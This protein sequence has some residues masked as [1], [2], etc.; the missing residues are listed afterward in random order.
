MPFGVFVE[1]PEIAASGLVHVSLL[2]HRFL[3]YNES[4]A[5]LS[6][7]G[8]SYRAGDRMKVHVARVDFRERKLDFVPVR[9]KGKRR[10]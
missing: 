7:A 2:S 3:R 9:E 5:T 1:I 8:E 6:A 10:L 4:D